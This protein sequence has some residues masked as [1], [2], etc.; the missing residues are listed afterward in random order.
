L[1]FEPKSLLQKLLGSK[2]V[3]SV[4]GPDAQSLAEKISQD[5]AESRRQG[6]VGS[7]AESG[8]RKTRNGESFGKYGQTVL[9]D[10]VNHRVLRTRKNR[11]I[12]S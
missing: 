7:L 5:E 3:A 2:A 6:F 1:F 9:K 12:T 4:L 10:E 11:K 8:I